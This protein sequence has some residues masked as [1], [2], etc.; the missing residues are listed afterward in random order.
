MIQ[1]M[2]YMDPAIPL[3]IHLKN[4]SSLPDPKGPL[5]RVREAELRKESLMDSGKF[6]TALKTD[7][8]SFI[9]Q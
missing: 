4:C 7:I 8:H 2:I 1:G 5:G 6:N 9:H 3:F